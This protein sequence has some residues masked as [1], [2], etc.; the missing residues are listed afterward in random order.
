MYLPKDGEILG[1]GTYI[2]PVIGTDT[3]TGQ[4]PRPVAY[5]SWGAC[6]T[7]VAVNVD[8]GE[9]KVLRI[10]QSFD[11]GQPINPKI[12]EGQTEGGIGMGIGLCLFEQMIVENGVV[13]NPNYIDY[14]MP[15]VMEIPTADIAAMSATTVPHREGPFGAKGFA[16]GGLLPT[17]PSITNA[18]ADAVGVRIREWPITR[19]RVLAAIQALRQEKE[20]AV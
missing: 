12:C 18:I 19:E 17:A 2:S 5:Y 1:R 10:A 20:R 6:T 11:M 16:E 13:T 7:E 14:R 8:T 9:V 4:S 15:S 3:E